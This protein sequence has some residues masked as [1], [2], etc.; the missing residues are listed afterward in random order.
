MPDDPYVS[1]KYP[2]FIIDR[3]A[4]L[5]YNLSRLDIFLSILCPLIASAEATSREGII[6]EQDVG[7]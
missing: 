6:R 2:K 7:R 4:S 1:R 5:I 3:Q